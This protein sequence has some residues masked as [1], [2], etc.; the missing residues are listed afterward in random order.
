M[1]YV[2][3]R[4]QL[5]FS[6]FILTSLIVAGIA[7]FVVFV[8]PKHAT[9]TFMDTEFEAV[10]VEKGKAIPTLPVPEKY[11]YD[12]KGWYYSRDFNE[13][14]LVHEGVDIVD[15]DI[16][17]YPKFTLASFSITFDA[18][19]GTG[20]G[21][22]WEDKVYNTNFIFPTS[23]QAGVSGVD[24]KV[25]VGWT[26]T[27]TTDETVSRTI[28]APGETAQVD[29]KDV[30]FYAV[31]DNPK[32]TIHFVVGDGVE[33]KPNY[34]D[35]VGALVP[36][37]QLVAPASGKTGH[38]FEGW[39]FNQYFT[40]NK[41]K[42]GANDFLVPS[43]E[44]G[45]VT[46]YAKWIPE[47][48]TISFYIGEDEYTI[49][50]VVQ[51][52]QV[53][54]GKKLLESNLPPVP[55]VVGK[56][57]VGWCVD[58]TCLSAY[59]Y[60]NI[61]EENKKLYAKFNDLQ[62]PSN[63]TPAEYF[64][65]EAENGGYTITGVKAEYSQCTSLV[66]PMQIDGMNVVKIGSEL[67]NL[68]QLVEV[69][70][71]F[72]ITEIEE[73]AFTN[74]PKLAEF[75]LQSDSNNF[76]VEDGVLYSKDFTKLIRYP[77]AKTGTSFQTKSSTL[78]IC[79]YAF[80]E[81]SNLEQL[82]ITGGEIKASAFSSA[83]SLSKITLGQGVSSV[84]DNAFL[85]YSSLTELVSNTAVIV[86][87]DG[88]IYNSNQTTL[89]KFFN[90]S[91]N[92]DFVAPDSVTKVLANA[93]READNLISITLG[94]NCVDIAKSAI[95]NCANLTTITLMGDAPSTVNVY[96]DMIRGCN[97]LTTI[98]LNMV[99]SNKF[100]TELNKS[101]SVFADKLQQLPA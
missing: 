5:Y 99:D 95:R 62:E 41:I 100:Y 94:K 96:N 20:S 15:F 3:K 53:E 91:N 87:E 6:V 83:S 38:T 97:S 40:G 81:V 49:D 73:G 74:C 22:V 51:T 84:S 69:S 67:R 47:I 33:Y 27:N 58:E 64:E 21:T 76:S 57:F 30:V 90:K 85:D 66:F 70:F 98:Y 34:T 78:I 7:I 65:G 42:P 75:K 39:Y 80:G 32:T 56:Q 10:E 29:G 68:G 63:V 61:I 79:S 44:T 1:A 9:L 59:N 18:N 86:V 31:W 19:G 89:I 93:F 101:N 13:T 26:T 52:V 77:Q 24:G 54:Y 4:K 25:L 35:Y 92:V 50:G 88:V 12:F 71:P 43:S 17:L 60:E 46:L 82:T 2:S 14:Q 55:S 11:G 8:M 37:D 45:S 16:T 48:Y 72:T 23:V 36:E 28:Y